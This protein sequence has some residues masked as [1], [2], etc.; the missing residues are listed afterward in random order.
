MEE[1][2]DKIPQLE[3]RIYVIGGPREQALDEAL[4]LI[5]TLLTNIISQQSTI[6]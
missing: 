5:R 6:A 1:I 2:I 4:T 3:N